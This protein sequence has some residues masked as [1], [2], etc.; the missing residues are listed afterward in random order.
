MTR[1]SM[2]PAT[3]L[4]RSLCNVVC[5]RTSVPHVSCIP[6]FDRA[7][8]LLKIVEAERHFG[9]HVGRARKKLRAVEPKIDRAKK[10]PVVHENEC[11]TCGV[12]P[13]MNSAKPAAAA[14]AAAAVAPNATL[15]A[16]FVLS[17][18]NCVPLVVVSSSLP[19]WTPAQ[20]CRMVC[21]TKSYTGKPS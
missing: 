16:L 19:H 18:P 10:L 17:C 2:A 6:S 9:E 1:S 5:G 20:T 7:R 8:L 14:P 11:C 15:A 13:A 21:I 4:A 3:T 12:Q